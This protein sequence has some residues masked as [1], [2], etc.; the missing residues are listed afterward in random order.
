MSDSVNPDVKLYEKVL[1]GDRRAAHLFCK[2]SINKVFGLCFFKLRDQ[3]KAEEITQ[4][5]FLKFFKAMRHNEISNPA[6]AKGYLF[7]IARNLCIDYFRQ[8]G[9]HQEILADLENEEK[10]PGGVDEKQ[11]H[12]TPEDLMI[13]EQRKSIFYE[14]LSLL[15]QEHR[16]A[17]YLKHILKFSYQ[18]IA[19][20]LDCSVN[21]IKSRVNRAM[22]KLARLLKKNGRIK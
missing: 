8:I 9:G 2:T 18:E 5:A 20:N 17:I 6:K 3:S 21:A 13:L 1:A 16:E 4:E 10:Q 14:K 12:G 19:D 15:S 11:S 22:L 7:Q